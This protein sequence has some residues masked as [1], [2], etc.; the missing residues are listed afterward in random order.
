MAALVHM[1]K[2]DCGTKGESSRIGGLLTRNYLD[3]RALAHTVRA[4]HP[5]NCA[6]GQREA[7]FLEQAAL[8]ICLRERLHVEHAAAEAR[9]GHDGNGTRLDEL[10]I[11]FDV[12][13]LE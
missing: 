4:D 9:T 10:G 2:H 1:P 13:L 5:H 3:K 12:F 8:A 11:P 6:G 7:Q